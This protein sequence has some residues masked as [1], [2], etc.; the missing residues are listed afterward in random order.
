M[1]DGF[2]CPVCEGSTC[3]NMLT[4]TDRVMRTTSA[5]FPLVQCTD[6]GLLRLHPP[7][8]DAVLEGAYAQ[9]Y[10]P[11]VRSGLS[12]RAKS[13]LERRSVRLLQRYLAAPKRVLDVGC[14]TGDLLVAVRGAGN[15]NVTG[16][17]ISGDAAEAARRRGLNVVSGDLHAAEFASCSFD[18]V[19]LS[20][21]IEHVRDP[22]SLLVEI[23]RVLSSDGALIAWLPNVDSTEASLLGHFWIGY[24]APRHLT[25]FSV[26]TLGLALM[27]AGFEIVEVRHEAVGLEWAWGLRLLLRERSQSAE[28]LL[29]RFHPLL[30][31][32]MSPLSMVSAKRRRSGRVRVIAKKRE[33]R[34]Q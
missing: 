3:R 30:I 2:V 13:A 18:T 34:S 20:H 11:H 24:D 27:R 28:R 23:N 31:L 16:V 6:C 32:L 25:T 4:L 5:E 12:G 14:A 26:G 15:R 9:D 19:L 22:L 33:S 10:A 21:T 1:T 29:G 8:D 17:E 7:P